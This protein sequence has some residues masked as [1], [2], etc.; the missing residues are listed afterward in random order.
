MDN[1]SDQFALAALYDATGGAN[2]R[3]N[4]NWCTDAPLSEWY[5]VTFDR[6]GRVSGLN[7][8][9][10]R[11]GGPIPTELAH[12]TSLKTLEL[13][14][15]ELTGPLPSELARLTHLMTLDLGGNPLTGPVP[16]ELAQLTNLK[17]LELWR[18]HSLARFPPS[19]RTS[20]A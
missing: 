20:P 1:H 3:H 5:G 7:L 2:W 16:T 8:E 12:L 10:N 19:W 14:G 9:N 17:T 15:N 13:W 18:N 6:C 11:L 4:T